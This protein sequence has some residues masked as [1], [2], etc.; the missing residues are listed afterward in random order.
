[1]KKLFLIIICLLHIVPTWAEKPV[2]CPTF[3]VIE[4]APM[5]F[6]NSTNAAT[7]VHWDYLTEIHKLSNVCLNKI[8]LPYPRIWQSIKQGEHDGGI[9]FKSESRSIFIE[10]VAPIRT[11]KTVVIALKGIKIEN[12]ADLRN[13]TIGKTRGTHLSKQ[14]DQDTDLNIIE[15][16]N[17]QQAAKMIKHGRIDAIAGSA[18]V[19]SY[20][21]KANNVLIYV[22]LENKLVLGEKEQWLQFSKKSKH[23]NKIPLLKNAIERLRSNGKFDLIMDKYYGIEWRLI[24]Q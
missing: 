7:G 23:L 24:N 18:L 14:F 9:I 17:Y 6:N 15:L 1:M 22:D 11:V 8:L 4:N 20:Q 16:S 12:Y 2:D 19:L 21:L 3:H 10:Y 13:I 5:G